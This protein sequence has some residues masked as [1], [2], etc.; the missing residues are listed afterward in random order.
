[1]GD[2]RLNI[3]L[4]LWLA[5][6]L[7]GAALSV[8]LLHAYQLRRH[9]ETFQEQIRRAENAGQTE[10]TAALLKRYL[11]FAPDDTDALLHYGQ[12][13]EKLTADPAN[14]WLAVAAYQQVLARRPNLAAVRERLATLLLE[15]EDYIGAREQIEL[16][17]QASPKDARLEGRLPRCL[18]EDGEYD[19]A[20]RVYEKAVEHDPTQVECYT[21]L[22]ALLYNHFNQAADEARRLLAEVKK[23]RPDWSRVALLDA[24]LCE[25]NRDAAGAIGAYTKAFDEGERQ[26]WMVQRLMKLLVT[27]GRPVEADEVMGRAQQQIIPHGGFAQFAAETALRAGQ[28]E[29]AA[30]LARLAVPRE[31]RDPWA[32]IWL[33][34]L[35]AAANRKSEAE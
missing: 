20:L 25:L 35:L 2:K 21:R 5:G 33:G 10:Q 16:Q 18:E 31:S 11:L 14:R 8:H 7:A 24:A 4:V 9:A 23:S 15:L 13:L 34:Q 32:F 1:M 12:A 3:R 29:R 30:S 22:A 27:Q 26:S 28:Y 6:T 17:L 19:Q